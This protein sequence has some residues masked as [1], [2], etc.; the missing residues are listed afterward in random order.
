MNLSIDRVE[1]SSLPVTYCFQ[2]S[3]QSLYILSEYFRG[4][5]L[6]FKAHTELELN[7]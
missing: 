4:A 7:L 6:F 2:A 1:A 3:E 5:F